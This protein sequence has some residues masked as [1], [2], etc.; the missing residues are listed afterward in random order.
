MLSIPHC[1]RVEPR[2]FGELWEEAS[3][4]VYLGVPAVQENVPQ[5]GEAG[6]GRAFRYEVEVREIFDENLRDAPKEMEFRHLR[7]H[8]FFGDE[9]R[10]G[11]ES[12][13]VAKLVRT[14]RAEAQTALDARFVPPVLRCGASEALAALLREIQE[15]ARAQAL[16]LSASLPDTSRMANIESPA[17]LAGMIKLQ[18]VN[19]GAAI[20]DQIASLPDV[21]PF[22][23][24]LEIL[25]LVG[26]LAVFSPGRVVPE[27]PTYSH[28]RLDECF[29]VAA[30]T[31][32]DL[33]AHEI[34][35]PYDRIELK[36]DPDREGVFVAAVPPDWLDAAPVFYLGVEMERPAD[37]V[38]DL[39]AAAVKLLAPDDLETVLQG[40]LPGV[41]L[42]PVRVPPISFPK[43]PDLHFFAIETEGAS[44][45]LWTHVL[46]SRRL[47]VISALGAV[48][49][50]DYAIYVELRG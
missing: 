30:S 49:Q 34:S 28:D 23:A 35:L 3:M 38:T 2:E 7:G 10:S 12:L 42:E 47:M 13:Q 41:G 31:V 8:L 33:L 45:E 43:R 26:E 6:G 5:T 37:E 18:A 46:D 27:L 9:D 44:R 39:V 29:Q 25:R 24:Y 48:E 15:K 36:E 11:Y 19:R 50:V 14:G 4:P 16:D 22:D 32:R 40:V 1:G 21:H 17:D 20:L